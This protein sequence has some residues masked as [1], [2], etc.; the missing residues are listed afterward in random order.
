MTDKFSNKSSELDSPATDGFII[1]PNNSLIFPQTTRLLYV[2]GAGTICVM[3]A[4]KA[5]TNTVLT[6]SVS[7]GQLLPLRV[8]SVLSTNTTATSIIGFF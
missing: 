2:G 4:N 8:Q 7:A 1:T 3:M 5:N 6:I